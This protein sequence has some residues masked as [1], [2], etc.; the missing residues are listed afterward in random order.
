MLKTKNNPASERVKDLIKL[1]LIKENL[2]L[3]ALLLVT[4]AVFLPFSPAMPRESLDPSWVFGM[5]EAVAQG[6]SFGKDIVFTFGPYASIYTHA[7]HPATDKLMIFGSLFLAISFTIAAYL[8]FRTTSGLLK[9]GLLVLLSSVMYSRDALFFFYPMLV[10]IQFYHWAR[11]FDSKRE[12]S[13]AEISLNLALL[14]PFGLFPLIKGTALIA[15]VAISVLSIALLARRGEWRICTLIVVIPLISL[16]AFWLLSGQP[17][18]GLSDYFVGL[19]PII[20][21]YTEAMAING[22]PREYI[23]YTVAAATLLFCLF[24]E[25]QGS[26]YE[27]SVVVL[28]F[29]LPL[30]LAFKAGFVR[31]D[32]HAITSA[33]MILLAALL[34]GTL[35]TT[36][37][38][39][40]VLLACL[41]AWVSIDA[42]HIK[43]STHSIMG[44]IKNTYASSW[45][46][47][48]R[49]I[50]DPEALTRNFDARVAEIDRRGAIPRLDGSVDIYSFDQSYLISSGNKWSP[51]PIFQSYSV[52]TAKLAELNKMHLLSD[53]RPENIIF[54]VQPIDGRLPSL[55]DGASWPVLLSN[56]EP[57]SFSNG[58]LFLK[59]RHAS[60]HIFEE[61]RKI[62]GGFYSLGEQINLPSSDA[63]MFVKVD[64]KKSFLG[65]I[66]N[67]LF[68]PSQLAIKLN[69][70][71]GVTR[72][73]RIVAGMSGAGFVISPLIENTE[74]LGL[75]FSDA[76]LLNDKTVK[77]IEII[78]PFSPML[79]KD[80]FEIGFYQL[81]IKGSSGFIDKMGF[82]IPHAASDLQVSSASHCDG[83][84]DFANGVSP[85]PQ[86]IRA[87][88]LLNINGWLAASVDLAD[89]PDRV[90][91]V[92]SSTEGKRY[93]IA[94]KRT[95]RPD[96]GAH[97]NKPDLNYSGYAATA[98]VSKLFGQ[99]HL[100]LA[101]VK[102]N[103]ILVCPQ[104]NIPIKLN[105]D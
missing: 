81:D 105:Q 46:G 45:A 68:K 87:A 1:K 78:A 56:Y 73:Y 51:R 88:A 83:S 29:L 11:S 14:V 19:L 42:T 13:A 100:G 43:T 28:M 33:T 58:Y 61:P 66:A 96:V 16:V 75:L 62:G 91:L 86:S 41:V 36:Q 53:N 48:M 99:Y 7:Y 89:V 15:C 52:Y 102:G 47:L 101:Y 26:A 44:N 77:S 34:A 72:E 92:L 20:S 80:S 23:L 27:K 38:S 49:R 5:N 70:H 63:A 84:I 6:M 59:N 55:E 98:N 40:G 76:N 35:L 94:A 31:H 32:V 24:R 69:L 67:I 25:A 71:N 4:V 18:L 39:L 97:F 30:F 74:E 65:N 60:D 3:V 17:F 93:F 104:F 64:F 12:V 82:S 21:G 79:W 50:K 57:T 10:G 22:K 95:Q 54:K 90:Y 2:F 9:L 103:E 37:V 8:N 85:P